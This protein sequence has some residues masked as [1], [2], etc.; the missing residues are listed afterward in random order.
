MVKPLSLT[1]LE[2]LLTERFEEGF[3]SLRD[4]PQP[5]SFKDMDKAT[6]RIVSAIQNKEKIPIA[7]V[8]TFF[9]KDQ[10]LPYYAGSLFEY[11][12]LAP[13]D[14]MYWALMSYGCEKGYKI[15][16]EELLKHL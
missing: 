7:G 1:E 16:S 12:K 10:I 11:R 3:L 4:L 6:E 13:N 8:L 9:F 5:S 15:Y 14:F 2:T